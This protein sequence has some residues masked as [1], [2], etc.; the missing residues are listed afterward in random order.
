MSLDFGEF[1]KIK[2]LKRK[3]QKIFGKLRFVSLNKIY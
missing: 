3:F 2:N 1:L